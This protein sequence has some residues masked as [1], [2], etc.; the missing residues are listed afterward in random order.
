MFGDIGT[1]PLYSLTAAFA[2][3]QPSSPTVVYGV[4][5]MLIWT[6]TA[7][8]TLLYVTILMRFDNH[9]EGGILA[10]LARIRRAQP[11]KRTLAVATTLALVGTGMFI[12]DGVVTPAISVLSAVE[13]AGLTWASASRYLAPITA[14]I[15]L[16]LFA[17]QRSGTA[18]I[19][20]LFGPTMALWFGV[21]TLL[22]L[23]SIVQTPQALSVLSPHWIVLL[24]SESP[25]TAFLALGGVILAVTGAEALFADMGHFG[26]RAITRAWFAVVYPALLIGYVGQAA[27]I[28]R[29]PANI[30][31]PYFAMVPHPLVLPVVL[32]AT[33]ATV[34]ASQSVIS[35]AFSVVH[36]ASRLGLL[37]RM[38]T[39]HTSAVVPGQIYVPSVNLF[40]AVAVTAVVFAFRSSHALA[41]AYGIAVTL[42]ILMTTG[43]AL[44]L[45]SMR[46]EPWLRALTGALLITTAI[47]VV[48]NV[49]KIASGGWLTLAIGA[50]LCAA[51]WAWYDGERRLRAAKVASQYSIRQVL[52]MLQGA[53]R[54]PGTTIYL[55]HSI[56][57]APES[58]VETLR[59][60]GVASENIIALQV[61]TGT[62]P[63]G[64]RMSVQP[65]G[66]G[67]TA[68]EME[69]GYREPQQVAQRLAE[70]VQR[71]E[72]PRVSVAGA[73]FA[74]TVNVPIYGVES[75][76]PGLW[77]RLYILL[78]RFSLAWADAFHLPVEQ[79][80]LHG[81]E[82]RL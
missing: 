51:M 54:T 19:G 60:Y 34:I 79:T 69:F 32:L 49:P 40:L 20:N 53:R 46:H 42:T 18:R 74:Y 11:N 47:F 7:I 77:Q 29:E 36:Q 66:L 71:G 78:K 80:V 65:L 38:R 14:G 16:V 8:V 39:V 81:R 41:S 1:S 61:H 62:H 35:G 27:A 3:D 50:A 67:I 9:G 59:H 26:R 70:A 31:N 15:L 58:L 2:N 45:V 44:V 12:G 55:T 23:N 25:K 75:T 10:L 37:P 30:A 73:I 4:T 52:P 28:T 21:S 57:Y 64:V 56:N 24:I 82:F 22:G 48:G 13:G 17:I 68:V 63:G 6:L 33:A 76:M 72:L 43:L 5:S